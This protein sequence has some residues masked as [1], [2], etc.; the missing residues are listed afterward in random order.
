MHM[1]SHLHNHVQDRSNFKFMEVQK[2]QN[3]NSE[4]LR[5]LAEAPTVNHRTNIQTLLWPLLK[6]L[7]CAASSI[8]GGG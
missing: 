3:P 5:G 2:Q 8:G 1:N 7:F 4:R 6:I